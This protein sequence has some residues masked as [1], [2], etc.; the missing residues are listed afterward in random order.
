[1][2]IPIMIAAGGL[3]VFD[4][5]AI[6]TFAEFLPVVI[7]GLI[8]AGIVGYLSIRWL[9]RYLVNH[10]FFGFAMY[11]IGVWLITFIVSMVRG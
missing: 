10:S 4:M 7:V 6:P 11:C 1:M 5:V 2:S 9:L 3:A 8:A